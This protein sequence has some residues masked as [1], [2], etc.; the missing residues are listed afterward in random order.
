MDVKK[1]LA[2]EEGP[3][4]SDKFN[5]TE[6]VAKEPKAS[7]KVYKEECAYCFRTPQDQ[8]SFS[9]RGQR[10]SSQFYHSTF[11]SF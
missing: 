7:D 2:K 9:G 11:H 6:L 1:L 5:M 8:G 10:G 4:A 3:E